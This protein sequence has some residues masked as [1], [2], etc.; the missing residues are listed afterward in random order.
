L[1]SR[2][3]RGR[4]RIRSEWT[5]MMLGKLFNRGVKEG[6]SELVDEMEGR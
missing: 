6:L 5:R 1:L 3:S 2:L 4:L